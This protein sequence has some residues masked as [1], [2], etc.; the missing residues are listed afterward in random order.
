[1]DIYNSSITVSERN[2]GLVPAIQRNGHAIP[3]GV[4]NQCSL[5]SQAAFKTYFFLAGANEQETEENDM[6]GE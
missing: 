1:M 4:F 2:P 5:A 6:E 3:G